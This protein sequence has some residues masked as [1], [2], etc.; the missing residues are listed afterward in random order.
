MSLSE[1]LRPG[2]EAAPWVIEEVVN[3]E[4]KLELFKTA[5]HHV[6]LSSQNSMSSKEECGKI[7]RA[8]LAKSR[9]QAIRQREGA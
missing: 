4:E 8:A 7:A 3:L 1:R 5:L 9:A 6:S 2:S